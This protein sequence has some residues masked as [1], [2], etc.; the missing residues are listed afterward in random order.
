MLSHKNVI[1]LVDVLYDDQK[2]KMYMVMEY[3]VSV[4]QELLDSVA[5]K[6]LPIW[7]AHG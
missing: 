7:Q 2:Q 3:C 4:I 1:K 6:K 5:D